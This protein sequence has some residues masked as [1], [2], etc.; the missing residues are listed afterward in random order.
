MEP[1][2]SPPP[3]CPRC[4]DLEQKLALLESRLRDLE[5]KL[6]AA[7]RLGK[8]QAAPFCKVGGPKLSPK[9]P[10]RKSGDDHGT[11]AHRAMPAP[12][13]VTEAIEVPLPQQCDHCHSHDIA[14]S[15]EQEQ[16]YQTEIPRVPIVRRFDIHVGTCRG[17]GH[18]VRGRHALQTSQVTGAASHQLGPYA[19]GAIT[20]LNKEMGLSHGKVTAVFRQLFGITIVRSTSARSQERTAQVCQSAY[21]QIRH[22]HTFRHN[23]ISYC[24]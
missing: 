10:G 4:R 8:R 18:T 9:L 19:H 16:Q 24:I 14:P 23:F 7:L 1:G 21:E 22:L 2:A 15:S 13:S 3:D 17:C 20:V 6:K 5:Q 12:E 11:H